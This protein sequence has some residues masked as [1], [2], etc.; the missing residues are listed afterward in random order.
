MLSPLLLHVSERTSVLD[1]FL[2]L[3]DAC[4]EASSNPGSNLYTELSTKS[5]LATNLTAERVFRHCIVITE[6]YSIYEAFSEAALSY[7]LSRLPRYKV[8][9]ELPD[10]FKTAYRIGIARILKDSEKR[11]FRHLNIIDVVSKF[12]NSLNGGSPWD[13]VAEA[14]TSH[15]LN[16]RKSEFE[17]IYHSALLDGVWSS[18]EN[19]PSLSSVVQSDDANTTLEEMILELVTYRNDATHG[20]PDEILGIEELRDRITFVQVFCD[21]LAAFITRC[22]VCEEVSSKPEIVYG[23]V[24]ETYSNN[25]SVISCEHGRIIVGESFYFLRESDCIHSCIQ[26]LQVNDVDTNSVEITHSGFEVGIKT[27]ERV[28]LGARVVKIE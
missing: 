15:N 9:T 18:L 6:L 27:S 4:D 23:I 2:S 28:R 21:A 12:L 13:F 8:F 20:S 22:I 11:K 16:L 7:W 10:N 5:L 25:V 19:N 17:R 3:C 14:L 26:S 24:T 1:R